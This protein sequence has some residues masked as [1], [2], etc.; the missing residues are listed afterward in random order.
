M[1]DRDVQAPALLRATRPRQWA[2][3]V[4]VLAAPLAAGRIGETEVA[5]EA[6]VTFVLFCAASAAV[7]LVNDT[8]DAA[9]DRLHPIKRL[10][11]I[12]AGELSVRTA[13]TMAAV[14]ATVALVGSAFVSLPLLWVVASY[15]AIQVAYSWRLKHE[16]VLDLAI[17]ASGFVLRAVAGGAASGIPISGPFLLVAGFGALFI[18][19][20]KRYSELYTLGDKVGTR[21]SLVAYSESYLRFV[22]SLA[23]GSAVIS[24][25]LWAIDEG[26]SGTAPWHQISIA[27]F[28]VGLLRYAADVDAGR[29]AEPE[30]I[31][32]SDR[33]L[34]VVGLIW[35]IVVC[36]GV[37]DV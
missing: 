13:I 31:I 20:G 35:L 14:L 24:Y 33:V 5:L 25:A 29:A 28:V 6:A 7:Y 3:N 1:T 12:A 16:P 9:V 26:G 27:G 19:A 8:L 10:R 34:Q 23:A 36:L 2:K 32:W 30:D 4:L 21:R 18:V 15:F 11:P 37:F 17:V 22:W